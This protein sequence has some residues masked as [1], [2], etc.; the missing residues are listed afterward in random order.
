[1]PENHA[2]GRVLGTEE[3]TPL[4]WW[5]AVSSDAY[6][7]LGD[8]VHVT[9]E[10]PGVGP[11]RVSGIVD[12]VTAAHE[13]ATYDSDVFLADEGLLPVQLSRAAH[14]STTRIE[15]EYWVPPTPGCEVE[16]ARGAERDQALYFDGM[17]RLLPAGQT[18]DGGP[19]YA[20]Y[21]FLDGTRG[22][23]VS[24]SGVSGVATK[25]SF[26][27]FLL[28]SVFRSGVL[29]VAAPNTKAI[30][31]NVKGEDLLFLDKPNSRLKPEDRERYAA[32]GLPADPF[33]SVGFWSPVRRGLA[34][35]DPVVAEST[36]RQAG[37]TPYFWTVRDVVRE[38]LLR[39]MFVDAHDGNSQISD[40]AARVEVALDRACEDHPSDPA[41]VEVGTA[42]GGMQAIR[43]F[44]ELCKFITA[45]LESG[46]TAWTG[47][48]APGTI[49]A[50]IRR[51]GS[52]EFHLG[53]LIRGAGT[54]HPERHRIAWQENQVTVIDIHRLHDRA[55]RFV[56]GSTIAKL[57]EQKERSGTNDPRVYI[58]LDEL[59]KYAPRDGWSPIK[60]VLL[61]IAERGRSLGILLIGCQQTSSEVEQ[62]II[63]NSAIRVVGRL[64]AAEAGRSEYGFLNETLRKRAV[65]L[66]PGYMLV[67]QPTIPLAIE[68]SF[69]FPSWAT[70]AAEVAAT[71][72]DDAFARFA[73]R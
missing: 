23:H 24:I 51:L 56:V 4:E 9:S 60:E 38:K 13:G 42:S 3:S 63:A 72:S 40:L 68:V 48:M 47:N 73:V 44:T 34:P 49:S 70:R 55:Q 35:A 71:P 18:R 12:Q 64:D 62:R 66:K 33:D 22:A 11:V 36:S 30:V 59:N 50:F 28:Y 29:G 6:L 54:T 61:D 53:H 31:F 20:D 14:V 57:Y 8:V 46:Q 16:R 58:V 43:S 37:I 52:A 17:E 69:P 19:F 10:V 7:Q 39:Y 32:L 21:E 45:E 27:S 5:V 67:Q 2:V 25:T 41:I 1:M 26:A 15:P 65:L